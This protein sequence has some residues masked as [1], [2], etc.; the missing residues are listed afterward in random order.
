LTSSAPAYGPPPEPR[1]RRRGGVVGPLILIFLG[2]VFLL[3]NTGHLPPNFWVNLWR[4]WPLVLVLAGIELLLAH[5]VPWLWLAALAAVVLIVGA[6]ATNSGLP[7][8]HTPPAVTRTAQTDLGGATQATVTVRFGAGQLNVGPVEQ[9]GPNRLAEMHYE[10]PADL[11]PQ[12]GYAV[13]SRVGQL[14][15]QI[16]GRGPGFIPFSGNRSDTMRMDLN[17]SPAIPI[18]MLTVQSGAAD[19]RLDLSSLRVDNLDMSL[20]AASTWVRMPQA[21]STTAHISGGASTITIEVPQGVA[22]QI[23]HHGGLST[24]NVDMS[25]FPQVSDGVYQSSGY[26]SA[27]N[28]VDINLETGIATIQVS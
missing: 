7:L 3:Q 23:R 18:T 26:E 20:G 2:G 11:A 17:L 25:R 14:E 19:A 16:S 28:K 12:P 24:L 15:Y 1:R 21:G 27:Q 10:G 9:P 8:Q 6:V 5:R 22:A 13:K 4:L